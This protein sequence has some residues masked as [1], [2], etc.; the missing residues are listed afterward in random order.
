MIQTIPN[1]CRFCSVVSKANGEDPIGSAW[2]YDRWLMIEM[3]QPWAAALWLEHP[4]LYIIYERIKV[5]QQTQGIWLRPLVIAPD[6]EYS[7]RDYTRVLYYHRPRKRFARFEK[8]EFLLP[9]GDRSR[10]L[11]ELVEPLA[12]ALLEQSETLSDFASYRQ[13]TEV[14]RELAICTH[15]NVDVACAR[16]GYPIYE[17]LRQDYAVASGGQLRVWR[18]SHFGGH[19][20]APTAIDFPNGHYWGH[21]EP[22]ILDLLVYRNGAVAG[23]RPFY[24]GWAGLT[25]FEQIAEREIWMQ[26]GWNWLNYDRSGQILAIDE[27][28]EESEA[29]WAEVRID[30]NS[31]DGNTSG[32]YQ[33]RIEAKG[34]VTTMWN[35]GDEKWM[36]PVKQ[37]QVNQLIEVAYEE[38]SV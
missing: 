23:L 25:R 8:Q 3:P 27:T 1:D 37:Y 5:L 31:P 2:H 29:D 4:V 32:A 11:S 10:G 7:S 20:F 16:F 19:Q 13:Q 36:E 35:S 12:I 33:A 17:K 6:R 21:L 14:I 9:V 24:R 26:E 30:F 15:G 18:C 34:K 38:N 22:E 28:H